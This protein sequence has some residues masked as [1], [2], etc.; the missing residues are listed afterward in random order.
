MEKLDVTG[1]TIESITIEQLEISESGFIGGEYFDN[2]AHR[3][4]NVIH[5]RFTDGTEF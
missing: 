2:I 4:V 3:K 5:L 1:K